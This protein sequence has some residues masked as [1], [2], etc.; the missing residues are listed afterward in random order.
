LLVSQNPSE[1]A[2]AID[3][4]KNNSRYEHW[5][6]AAGVVK[7]PHFSPEQVHI[8]NGIGSL[9]KLSKLR[10]PSPLRQPVS[11]YCSLM[12]SAL[13][14]S[15]SA[16]P[17][18]L[19]DLKVVHEETASDLF[20]ISAGG[21]EIVLADEVG[22][23]TN[24]N[25]GLARIVSQA[26]SAVSPLIEHEC[27]LRLHSLLGIGIADLALAR[28]RIFAEKTLGSANIPDRVAHLERKPID[29]DLT[30][31]RCDSDFWFSDHLGKNGTVV[32]HSVAH[33]PTATDVPFP[34]LTYFSQTDHFKS[35]L[36]TLSA[37]VTAIAACNTVRWSLLTLTHEICH[38]IVRGVLTTLLPDPDKTEELQDAIALLNKTRKP[39][40][41][42]DEIR[43]YLIAS[44]IAMD[45]VHSLSEGVSGEFPV[46][47]DYLRE[48]LD[49]CHHEVEE[50]MVHVMDF[51]YFYDGEA[52]KYI[53]WI[54][55]SWGVIPNIGNRVPEY[56]LRTLCALNAMNLR[57]GGLTETT[58]RDQLIHILS[59]LKDSTKDL[60]VE[61]AL[62][63]LREHWD[64]RIKNA[65]ICRKGIVKIVRAF[66]FSDS[67]AD[68]LRQE[69]KAFG[70]GSKREGY[71]MNPRELSSLMIDNPLKFIKVYTDSGEPSEA[72]SAWMLSTIAFNT[73]D[74]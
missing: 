71:P 62:K 7:E 14:R 72:V 42:L 32:G 74:S 22:D 15:R 63:H 46:D 11:E 55:L 21:D 35:T 31:L 49:R 43:R 73:L 57:R 56:V 26:L 16:L 5:E 36:T 70:P 64:E 29:M 33:L 44:V 34:L 48:T 4:A 1:T 61:A 19:Q 39:A 24:T 23:L 41:L 6:I 68:S 52:D 51:M 12:A 66:L 9:T 58:S 13:S 38:A 30:R 3:W 40:H 67:I 45:H 17:Q 37:P 18:L 59:G 28:I 25:A 50:I 47:A 20:D 69:R 27:D 8:R 65:L 10:M 2:V 60:Y 54:W 53:P